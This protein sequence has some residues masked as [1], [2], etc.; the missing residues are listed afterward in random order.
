MA[1]REIFGAG[2]PD[3]RGIP[4]PLPPGVFLLPVKKRFAFQTE[5]I[6]PEVGMTGRAAGIGY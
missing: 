2:H 6:P 5:G 1:P 4:L 3:D